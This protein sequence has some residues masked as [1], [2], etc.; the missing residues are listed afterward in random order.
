MSVSC[1]PHPVAVS[2]FIICRGLCACTKMLWMCVLYVSFGSK[3]KPI[4]FGCIAMGSPLLYFEVQ[5]T[6]IYSRV[7]REQSASCFVW[8]SMRLFCFGQVKTVCRYGCIYFLA[9]LVLV[10]VDVMVMSSA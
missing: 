2:A 9:A 10:C 4:N 8:I 1:L 5:I 6:R 3:V 7:R